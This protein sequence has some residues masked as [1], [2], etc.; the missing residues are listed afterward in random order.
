MGNEEAEKDLRKGQFEARTREE[1]EQTGSDG[2]K[3][4]VNETQMAAKNH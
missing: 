1:V 4:P 3:D 2:E